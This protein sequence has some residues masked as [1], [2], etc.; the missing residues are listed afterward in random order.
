MI[1]GFY[2]TTKDCQGKKIHPD[3]WEGEIKKGTPLTLTYFDEYGMEFS[4]G[5]HEFRLTTPCPVVPAASCPICSKIVPSNLIKE[6]QDT[7]DNCQKI[8]RDGFY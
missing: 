5:L 8:S 3:S 2:I 4:D 7:D 1:Q 6:H